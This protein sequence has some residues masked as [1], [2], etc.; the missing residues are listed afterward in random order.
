[1]IEIIK[2]IDRSKRKELRELFKDIDKNGDGYTLAVHVLL[3]YLSLYI[4]KA[5]YLYRV[6]GYSTRLCYSYSS[7]IKKGEI[8]GLKIIL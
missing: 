3:K 8:K 2:F 1:M 5:H 7:T 4:I 6:S